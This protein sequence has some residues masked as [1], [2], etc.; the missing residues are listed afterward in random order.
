MSLTWRILTKGC[1]FMEGTHALLHLQVLCGVGKLYSVKELDAKRDYFVLDMLSVLF[2]FGTLYMSGAEN[3]TKSL[4]GL[5]IAHALL[6]SF[7]IAQWTL[8]NSFFIRSIK[9]WSAEK[10]HLNRMQKDG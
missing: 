6:H 7:Y 5:V 2:S 8:D 3:I 9:E 10:S 4:T 1:A